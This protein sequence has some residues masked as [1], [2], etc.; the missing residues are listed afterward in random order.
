[1]KRFPHA[2]TTVVLTTVL[3]TGTAMAS[4]PA[5][6]TK[7][8]QLVVPFAPGGNTDMVA[9]ILAEGLAKELKQ[10]V[11]VENR[12]GA[13]GLIATNYV[14]GT[15]PDG[16][17]LML[18]TVGLVTTPLV[19]AA[20]SGDLA[21]K[22]V[23][24]AQVA[25]VPKVLVTHPSF[26]ANSLAELV[27]H[28]RKAGKPLTFGSPGNGS[29]THLMG[30][31]FALEM[32]VP[33]VHVPYRGSAPAL[34]DLMGNQIDMIFED[35][36]PAAAFIEGGKLKAVMMASKERSAAFPSVPSAGE[37]KNDSLIVEPWN[38]VLA[39]LKTP[40][41]VIAT[42]DRAIRNVVASEDYR[43][44]LAKT[45]AQATYRDSAAYRA[46]IQAEAARWGSVVQKAG[47]P[48]Q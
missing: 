8:V 21:S 22:F 33:L 32:G 26:P 1:M 13:G 4:E 6:P 44:R 2:W 20:A 24:V 29:V 36:P 38:G 31:L 11:V 43:S 5:W 30:E 28:A 42:L 23:P 10:P 45:G 40:A 12:A 7:P 18:N 47:I 34:T 17:T 48:K 39:P 37:S 9:R 35:L 15:A 14:A 27:A 19:S 3:T 46:F 25:S 16:Y 41:P